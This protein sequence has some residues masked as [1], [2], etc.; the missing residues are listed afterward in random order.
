MNPLLS[1]ASTVKLPMS[2]AWNWR[3]PSTR[4]SY[5]APSSSTARWRMAIKARFAITRCSFTS[6]IRELTTPLARTRYARY[7]ESSGFTSGTGYSRLKDLYESDFLPVCQARSE[8][9]PFP[10]SFDELKDTWVHNW[11]DIRLGDPAIIVNSDKDLAQEAST[12][13]SGRSGGFWSAGP[14][15]AA[16]SRSKV[17]LLLLPPPH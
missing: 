7:G 11:K 15:S 16:D 10:K 6:L 14:S 13:T 3:A 4:S 8:G 1:E 17:L 2:A 12:S 9:Q 5:Q